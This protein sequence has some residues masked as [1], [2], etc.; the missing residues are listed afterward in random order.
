MSIRNS[1]EP[2][3]ERQTL[4]NQSATRNYTVELGEWANNGFPTQCTDWSPAPDTILTRTTFTQNA[5][6]C[7]QSQS[8]SRKES[9]I[10][11][12]TGQKNVLAQ[13]VEQQT[14]KAVKSS[15]QAVGTGGLNYYPL[16]SAPGVSTRTGISNGATSSNGTVGYQMWGPY[17]HPFKGG[18]Y[19]LKIYGTTSNAQKSTYDIVLDGDVNFVIP[20]T[21]LPANGSGI[22]IDRQISIPNIAASDFGMEIRVLTNNASDSVQITGYTLTPM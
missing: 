21:P 18:S 15:Q 14:L 16:S 6:D 4:Q 7:T 5:T 13:T 19:N 9:Y 2:V 8:R 12:V 1:G 11:N 10:D 20:P 3:V 17:V 22:L